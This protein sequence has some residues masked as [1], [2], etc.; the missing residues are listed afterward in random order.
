MSAEP[1]TLLRNEASAKGGER[2]VKV[3]ALVLLLTSFAAPAWTATAPAPPPIA[4]FAKVDSGL[5]RG[6]RPSPSA[7][8]YLAHHGYRTVIAFIHDPAEGDLVRAAGMRYV[9][10]PMT[11][12]LFG[13]STPNDHDIDRFFDAVLD[14][15]AGPAFMHCV[16][17]KDRTGAMAAIY[18]I[19]V[20]GWK[21]E[22]AV[23]EMDSLGF[24]R[25][26]RNL[27]AFVRDYKP[28]GYVARRKVVRVD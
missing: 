12:T 27:H 19:E 17:G 8:A 4:R 9:E 25:F 21:S 7:I 5:A 16:H 2:G 18:R 14:T 22:R 23:A 26:Y 6:A 11:A 15:T 1:N 24:N 10:I 3:P 20:S 28:R 13:A